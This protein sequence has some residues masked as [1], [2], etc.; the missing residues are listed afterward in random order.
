MIEINITFEQAKELENFV[1]GHIWKC[2]EYLDESFEEESEFEPYGIYDGCDTCVTR[3]HLM[4]A[5]EWL[6]KNEI[7]DL[8]ID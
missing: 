4:A 2:H 3:E 6:K 5:F 7:L 8:A 1:Q